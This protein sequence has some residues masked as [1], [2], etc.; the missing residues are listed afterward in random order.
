[1]YA[2]MP[3]AYFEIQNLIENLSALSVRRIHLH[4]HWKKCEHFKFEYPQKKC[5]HFICMSTGRNV[6]TS[7]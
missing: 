5:K 4:E 1:M 2:K 6:S 3:L 7:N